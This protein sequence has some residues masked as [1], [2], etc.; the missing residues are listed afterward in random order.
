V[1]SQSIYID[2]DP[3][4]A[5]DHAVIRVVGGAA[6]R[7]KARLRIK[8]PGGQFLGPGGWQNGEVWLD[9]DATQPDGHDLVVYVGPGVC[10]E[11]RP[12]NYEFSVGDV[13]SVEVWPS[14][15]SGFGGQ[16]GIFGRRPEMP[17]PDV[18]DSA[19]R[20]RVAPRVV[21]EPE[22]KTEPLETPNDEP[23]RTPLIDGDRKDRP[24]PPPKPFA[25]WAALAAVII[26]AAVGGTIWYLRHPPPID[27]HSVAPSPACG[28]A[29]AA[30]CPQPV[31]RPVPRP[32]PPVPCG[33]TT[34]NCA[35]PVVPPPP[36]PPSPQVT[37][38]TPTAFH[39]LKPNEFL[40][41]F[42]RPE[43]IIPEAQWRLDNGDAGGGFLL[44]F[45]A[46]RRG[47]AAAKARLAR[48]YD[49]TLPA[50]AGIDKNVSEAARNYKEAEMAGDRSVSSDR[51]RFCQHLEEL[52]SQHDHAATV[53]RDSYCQ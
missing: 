46:A 15:R 20:R 26:L 23:I 9:P 12:G 18:T 38:T 52:V 4:H 49:P 17:E 2:E 8:R 24:V 1:I 19:V 53:A 7:E 11:M 25:L 39:D 14:I 47:S 45:E 35:Q 13:V 28:T 44:M 42:P 41:R 51:H 31:P 21:P 5:A 50:I 37:P 16:A 48:I 40:K 32:T 36:P 10:R 27:I 29:G 6:S 30:A 34:P 3:N 43:D 22:Q 33:G